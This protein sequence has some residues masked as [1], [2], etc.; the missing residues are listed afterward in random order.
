MEWTF[1]NFTKNNYIVVDSTQNLTYIK[2]RLLS[3]KNKKQLE[4]TNHLIEFK[5]KWE[6]AK[7]ILDSYKKYYKTREK[8]VPNLYTHKKNDISKLSNQISKN[9]ICS[10]DST[11]HCSSF[12]NRIY[13]IESNSF[14]LPAAM[15]NLIER[16][17]EKEKNKGKSKTHI[18]IDQA[19]I[20]LAERAMKRMMIA[21]RWV[22]NSE[23]RKQL[24]KKQEELNN[25]NILL[26]IYPNF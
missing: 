13:Q 18:F 23:K 2:G 10:K 8:I 21:G 1:C 9:I 5:D 4:N 7:F 22:L 26:E 11:T 3:T 25:M 16:D 14:K 17:I 6:F 19:S 20:Y 24:R 12:Q 15:F